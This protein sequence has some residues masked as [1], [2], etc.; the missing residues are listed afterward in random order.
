MSA[1]GFAFSAICGFLFMGLFDYVFY[2]NRIFLLFWLILG[3]SS[4]AIR[5]AVRERITTSTDGPS[6][7]LPLH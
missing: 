5:A 6:L 1:L 2:N 7:D 4:A 3:L